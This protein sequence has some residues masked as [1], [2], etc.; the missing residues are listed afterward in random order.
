M[1]RLTQ[2]GYVKSHEIASTLKITGPWTSGN[3]DNAEVHL[4][5]LD[6]DTGYRFG[7]WF[8]V[9]ELL[10]EIVKAEKSSV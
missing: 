1:A 6:G 5:F 2:T 7:A 3:E 9:S 4:D 8:R 10:V